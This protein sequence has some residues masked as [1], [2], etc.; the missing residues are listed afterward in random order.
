M[1]FKALHPNFALPVRSSIEAG[2]LDIYMP[3]AGSLGVHQVKTVPLGFAAEVPKGFMAVLNVRSSVGAKHGL[4]L[5]NTVGYI[6]ADYRG[7]WKAVLRTKS[8]VAFHWQED[9][10]LLQ[11]ALVPILA[12]Q[13]ILVD[14]LDAT[15]RGVGGFGSTGS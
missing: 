11:F 4:E 7:E 10:R 9:E 2:A 14:S 1:R 13:P 6:D 15:E 5:N 12:V 8:G 3:E